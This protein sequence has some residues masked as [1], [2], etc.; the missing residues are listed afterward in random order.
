MKNANCAGKY[1][2]KSFHPLLDPQIFAEVDVVIHK[3]QQNEPIC[4][5]CKLATYKMRFVIEAP[6]ALGFTP[7]GDSLTSI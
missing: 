3:F 5:Y 6:I 4:S 2:G 7:K 1:C